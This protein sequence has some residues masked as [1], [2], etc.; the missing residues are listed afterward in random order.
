MEGKEKKLKEKKEWGK[1]GKKGRRGEKCE[2]RKV[3]IRMKRK[4]EHQK[5]KETEG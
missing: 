5:D 3:G 4:R 1:N 2:E